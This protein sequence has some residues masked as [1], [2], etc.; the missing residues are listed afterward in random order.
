[1]SKKRVKQYLMLLTVIGLV[2]IASGSGT[3]AS[4]SAET[5]NA[6]NQFATGTLALEDGVSDLSGTTCFSYGAGQVNNANSTGCAQIINVSTSP[7]AAPGSSVVTGTVEIKNT[8]TLPGSKFYVYAPTSS[9]CTDSVVTAEGTLNSG[10]SLCGATVMSIEELSQPTAS[11]SYTYCW[12]GYSSDS[13]TTCDT[14]P[15]DLD[16]H[17][18]NTLTNFDTNHNASGGKIELL[19]LTASGTTGAGTELA[20]GASRKFQVA[21]YLPSGAT[22]AV[23]GLKAVF[24]ITWHLDQ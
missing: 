4:F 9:D 23:Q 5:T 3:F 24:G 17:T 22:N 18:T 11:T 1:M 2:S 19:P 6:G 20:A 15:A 16:T 14:T 7:G 12:Y 10:Q 21:L 8:G 13:N